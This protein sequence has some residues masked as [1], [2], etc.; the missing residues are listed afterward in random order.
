MF[1]FS[2]SILNEAQ[3]SNYIL[4]FL[5]TSLDTKEL[6]VPILHSANSY[7]MSMQKSLYSQ[8]NLPIGQ[9][10]SWKS[11]LYNTK[12]FL[13]WI[14]LWAVLRKRHSLNASLLEK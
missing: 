4:K 14:P 5:E 10:A 6:S 9:I 12:G 7:A 2:F 8:K 13:Y 3:W 1:L 11:S